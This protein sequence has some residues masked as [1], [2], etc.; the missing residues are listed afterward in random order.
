MQLRIF[1]PLSSGTLEDNQLGYVNCDRVEYTERLYDI[2]TF[3]FST[4]A[5]EDFTDKMKTGTLVYIK[6][7]GINLW[8]VIRAIDDINA[9]DK[10]L[11][12]YGDSLTTYLKQRIVAVEQNGFDSKTGSTEEIVKYFVNKNLINPTNVNRKIDFLKN[13]NNQNRGNPNDKYMINRVPVVDVIKDMCMSEKLGFKIDMDLSTGYMFFD[14]IQGTDRTAFQD[15]RPRVIFDVDFGTA[16]SSEYV[17]DLNNY[18]NMFYTS[19][20]GAENEQTTTTLELWR[21]DEQ[22][23]YG[24]DRFETAL[25]VTVDKEAVDVIGEMQNIAYKEM[26][27]FDEE[28]SFKIALNGNLVY[29]KDY[30][31]GDFVTIQDRGMGIFKNVQLIEVTHEWSR[32]S[33]TL[34]GTFGSPL[35]NRFE[36]LRRD[37]SKGVV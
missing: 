7:K 25:N 20:T 37:L 30:K 12:R 17:E 8:G 29:N 28:V 11:N 36:I 9:L 34:V 3:S 33:Y 26:T 10:P 16:K 2:G 19:K 32:N 27:N 31:L 22:E 5:N 15:E 24:V 1:S 21:K 14:V 6:D 4:S 13:A 35:K 23:P 18:K